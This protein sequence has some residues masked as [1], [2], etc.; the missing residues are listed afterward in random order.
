MLQTLNSLLAPAVM[1]RLTLVANHV[2]GAEPVATERL[3]PHAGRTIDVVAA[4]WPS[5]LPPPPPCAFRVTPA[6][7]LEWSGMERGGAADLSVRI[8]ASNP[9]LLF[10]RL[11]AGEQPA[12]EIGGDAQFA[13]D[14][15]WLILNLRWDVEADLERFFGPAVA[16][17]LHRLGRAVARALRAAIAGAGQVAGRLRPRG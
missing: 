1:E 7:L 9:A 16:S 2:I 5:V 13:G 3:K 4:G 10:A 6:G 14:V 8:D 11:L 12:V 17:Q 15:N